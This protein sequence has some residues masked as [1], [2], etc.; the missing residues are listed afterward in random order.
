M[1]CVYQ[2]CVTDNV[3]ITVAELNTLEISDM[4]DQSVAS[5]M[6]E[7]GKHMEGQLQAAGCS[8][9]VGGNIAVVTSSDKGVHGLFS[10]HMLIIVCVF[11]GVHF[12]QKKTREKRGGGGLE[13]IYGHNS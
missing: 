11:N 4:M 6:G 12:I 13:I 9:S 5:L 10:V 2:V 8:D 7:L 3:C 1:P